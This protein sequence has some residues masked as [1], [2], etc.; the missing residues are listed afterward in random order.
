[1]FAHVKIIGRTQSEIKDSEAVKTASRNIKNTK[2]KTNE[3]IHKR[4]E[5]L[6]DSKRRNE[7]LITEPG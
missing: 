2:S 4:D 3:S 1:M 5:K 6:N 7:N